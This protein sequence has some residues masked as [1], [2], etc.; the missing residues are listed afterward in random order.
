MLN[1]EERALVT[2]LQDKII[3]LL[4]EKQ[5]ARRLGDETLVRKLQRDIDRLS[6]ECA[7]IRQAAEQ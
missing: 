3:A 7:E 1:H 2:D 6:N 5:E 4:V